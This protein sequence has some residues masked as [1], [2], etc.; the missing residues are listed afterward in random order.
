MWIANPDA[1]SPA[2]A[3]DAEQR[4]AYRTTITLP[5][6]VKFAA[7]YATGQDTVAAW[8]NG[9]QVLTAESAATL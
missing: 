2:I 4:F 8:V 9:A 7:L 1:K 6:A 3:K 5:Q